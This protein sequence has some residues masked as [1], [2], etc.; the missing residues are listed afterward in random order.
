MVH[1][2]LVDA[3]VRVAVE[4]VSLVM[5]FRCI[6]GKD[7]STSA[8][9]VLGPCELLAVEDEEVSVFVEVLL[10][11]KASFLESFDSSALA[12]DLIVVFLDFMIVVM[13]IVVVVIN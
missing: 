13:D 2:V 3:M 12:F 10:A 1:S 4:D 7:V 5:K 8:D 11:S 6:A 9:H